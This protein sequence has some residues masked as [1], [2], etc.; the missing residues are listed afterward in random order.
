MLTGSQELIRDINTQSLI[1]TII[2]HEPISR[3]ALAP[4]LNLTKATISSIVQT[5]IE[6][7]LLLEIGSDD[8]KKGRKPI[9]LKINRHCGYIISIDLSAEFIT[10]MTSDLL[11]GDCACR[12]ISAPSC[13]EELISSLRSKPSRKSCRQ[14]VMAVSAFLLVCT[15]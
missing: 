15:V 4:M 13:A 9:L 2:E 6:K 7:D 10:L 12:Q 11:G 1:R 5:L 3:A 14:A 8:T